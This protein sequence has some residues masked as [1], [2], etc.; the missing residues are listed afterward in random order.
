MFEEQAGG[1]NAATTLSLV[2]EAHHTLL[3]NECRLVELAAHWADLH[4]PDSQAPIERPLPGAEQGRQ[5]GGDGTPE[6][7]EFAAAE[8][9]ARMES[10]SGSARALM[11]DA[12]DLRHRLP[13]L[14]QLIIT[15]RVR[16]WQARKVAQAT[17]H[18]SRDSAMQVDAAVAQA[19][20]GLP[21]GR[22][23]TLLSAKIIEADP[24]AAEEQAKIWEAE[25]FVRSGRTNQSG[26]KL[27]IAKANAG[28][29]IYFLATVNRIAEILRLQ[30][31]MESVDV[32][33]SKA[34]G[35]LAQPALALQLL[36][37]FR[38]EQRPAPEPQQPD[39]P[40]DN[41]PNAPHETSI[42]APGEDDQ[43]E[44]EPAE[45]IIQPPTMDVRKL[46]PKVVLHIHLSEEALIGYSNG[47]FALGG[48]GRFEGVGPVTLGQVHRF[49]ADTNCDVRVQPVIDPRDTTPVDG[50]EIPRRIREAMFLRMPASCFP[51]AAHTGRLELDHTI[52]YLPP[53]RGGPPGQTAVNKLGPMIRFE[54]RVK[55]HG[56]WR[57]RQP[58]SGV[59]IWRSPN[60]AHYLVTNAGTY[61]LGNGP[62]ARQVWRA[63]APTGPRPVLAA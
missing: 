43:A 29:V 21:W 26:L 28:D 25:R 24:R 48:I 58:E 7:L 32:R 11:A 12:L 3:M 4:H 2:A 34:I 54:H 53:S 19:I 61:S 38:N 35:I 6:V 33:R 37:E 15:G 51:Y 18:L 17:R 30:G 60:R 56:R 52:S 47:K 39:E 8:F 22:F 23:E 31:D 45:L 46:R 9:G 36:W 49:L 50:Y 5:L 14:W 40:I 16:A 44:T 20:I 55:T 27:L 1:P 62:F 57:V 13:E 10:S 59:W 63:A 42:A 41:E